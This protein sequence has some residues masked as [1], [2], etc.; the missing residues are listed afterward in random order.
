MR[1]LCMERGPG[2]ELPPFGADGK[3]ILPPP[4]PA[5]GDLAS[6]SEADP[7]SSGI[8]AGDSICRN[9]ATDAGLPNPLAF[10]AWL[11]DSNNAAPARI[12]SNGPWV[13]PDGVP[14]AANGAELISSFRNTGIAV[15]ELGGYL[16][17]NSV[18]TGTDNDGTP[19]PDHCNNW[20]DSGV[21]FDG[22]VGVAQAS[23]SN[24]SGSFARSCDRNSLLYC[25]EDVGPDV[26]FLD[27]FEQ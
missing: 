25:I 19:E 6:W 14:V 4:L 1:L 26:L 8:E 13:R 2:P 23:A 18:W 20:Q 15:T 21:N 11:S 27:G 22:T 24:W 10:K 12:F 5:Q 17:N 16:V 7:G 9:L 3:L